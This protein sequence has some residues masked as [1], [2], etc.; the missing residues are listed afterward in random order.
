MALRLRS[1]LE[2][3]RPGE[4]FF[5]SVVLRRW[6]LKPVATA[7]PWPTLLSYRWRQEN[8]N[9]WLKSEGVRSA[10]LPP[11]PWGYGGTYEARII[12]PLLEGAYRLRVTLVQENWRWLDEKSPEV[13]DEI[14]VQVEPNSRAFYSRG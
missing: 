5:V 4:E 11:I 9:I 3:I 12:A 14:T 2:R 13:F 6:T 8:E 1:R 7:S 10:V